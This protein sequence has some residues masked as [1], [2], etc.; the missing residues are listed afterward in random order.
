MLIW[1]RICFALASL[2]AQCTFKIINVSQQRC[3]CICFHEV[4]IVAIYIQF[5][6]D[7]F[8]SL[9]FQ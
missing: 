5:T 7:T 9:N 1:R 3:P 4:A 2:I 8:R 6:T